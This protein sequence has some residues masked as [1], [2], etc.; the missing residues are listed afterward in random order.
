MNWG[1]NPP[2][3]AGK[4]KREPPKHLSKLKKNTT[5]TRASPKKQ[6]QIPK[7][8]SRSTK[9]PQD[10]LKIPPKSP[11]SPWFFGAYPTR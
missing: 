6:Q 10:P 9:I 1:Y 2:R 8:P 4:K 7:N 3:D 11:S 5:Y